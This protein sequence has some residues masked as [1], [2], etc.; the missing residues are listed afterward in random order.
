MGGLAIKIFGAETL[1][2][3]PLPVTARECLCPSFSCDYQTPV[4]ASQVRSDAYANDTSSVLMR[5]FRAADSIAFSL[6]KAGVKVA[7]LDDDDLGQFF[8]A[9]GTGGLFV[10]FIVDWRKVQQ[11]H[12][13]GLY[14]VIT[15]ATILGQSIEMASPQYRLLPFSDEAADGTVKIEVR[16]NGVVE[17]LNLDYRNTVV[18]GW[19]ES[20]R[21]RGRFGYLEVQY[22]EDEIV[23]SNYQRLQITPSI[24]RLYTLKTEFID[25]RTLA[26]LSESAALSANIR[27]T[28]YNSDNSAIYERKAV[29]FSEVEEIGHYDTSKKVWLNVKFK[30]AFQ[31]TK[32]N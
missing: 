7:D 1:P 11:T 25:E 3:A 18:G 2:P 22:N 6:E 24:E 32:R 28:D 31:I 10:G 15:D 27:I 13:N 17:G 8:G 4:F 16:S 26:L 19:P 14:Q 5:K 20:V 12:G 23:D 29:V 9:F 30:D 21:V